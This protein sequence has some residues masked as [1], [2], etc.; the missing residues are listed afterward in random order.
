M[1]GDTNLSP[2]RQHDRWTD[3]SRHRDR[4]TSL[5]RD[6]SGW[7]GT[8][9][10]L[11]LH[12]ACLDLYALTTAD[13]APFDRRTLRAADWFDRILTL[14][15]RPLTE[16]RTAACRPVGTCRDFSLLMCSILRQNGFA[17]RVRCGF[18]DYLVPGRFEDHWVCEYHAGGRWRLAD[19]QIDDV[20]R[21]HLGIDFDTTDLPDGRFLVASRAWRSMRHDG[22][23]AGHFG[24]GS[25]TGPWFMIVN[26]MR[27]RLALQ[28]DITSTWDEWRSALPFE[29]IIPEEQVRFADGLAMEND[30]IAAGSRPVWT[31]P[32]TEPFWMRPRLPA[33]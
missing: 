30:A 1:Q 6:V 12:D 33:S 29:E 3:P 15:D 11:L 9:S 16:R 27:D 17:S 28:G 14:S 25:A 7:A 5:S 22:H 21:R 2:Y 20:Q 4:I 24:H 19:P 10:E 32:P 8:V 23:V 26:L 31:A 13:V 18:A